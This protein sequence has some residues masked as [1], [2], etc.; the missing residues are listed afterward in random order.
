MATKK[1]SGIL[2]TSIELDGTK[3]TQSLKQLKS[4][5]N[6]TAKEYQVLEAQAKSSG[7]ELKASGLRVEGLTK[8]LSKNDEQIK[9][10]KMQMANLNTD[11]QKG[12]QAYAKLSQELLRAES[13]HTSLNNQL[14]KAQE[15][16][17][18]L[19]DGTTEL[20]RK[21]ENRNKL[22]DVTVQRLQAEGKA[23]EANAT[24]AKALIENKKDLNE[25]LE[26]EVNRLNKVTDTSGKSSREYT[27][28]AIKVEQLRGQ[29]AKTTN[30]MNSMGVK[31]SSV[32]GSLEELGKKSSIFS[33]FRGTITGASGGLTKFTGGV[34]KSKEGLLAMGASATATMAVVGKALSSIYDSQ[35][36]VSGLQAKTTLSYTKSKASISAI[37]KLYAQGYGDSIEDLQ[38]TYSKISQLNPNKSVKEL[39]ENT[40]LVSTYAKLSGADAEEVM[41]GADRATKSWGITYS[42]YFDNMIQ[43]Q[44]R[45]DDTAGDLS[46]NMSEYSQ[47]MAQM[48]LSMKDTMGLIDN[49][50]KSGAYNAD[51]LLDFTKEFGIS[52]NDGRMEKNV[53]SFN[54]QTQRMF[55]G[56]KEGKVTS[57]ELLK[58][59]TKDMAGMTDSTKEASLASTMWSALGEDNALKVVNSLG[60]TNKAFDKTKGTAKQTADQLKESNP[61]ELLKRSAT[62]S[63]SSVQM[64]ATQTKNFKKTLE[65]LQ[66]QVNKLI[67]ALIKNLP[68]IT[69]NIT[70]LV[71][72]VNAHGKTILSILGSILALH[73]ASKTINGLSG[74]KRAASSLAPIITSVGRKGKTAFMWGAKLSTKAFLKSIGAIKVATVT[75]G[76]GIGRAVKWTASIATK[77]AKLAMTGLLATARFTGNGIRLAFN[78][79]KENPLILLVSTITAVSV[80]LVELYKHNK[81]F[82]GFINGLAKAIGRNFS[83][84]IKRTIKAFNDFTD[85]VKDLWHATK[86]AFSSGW[87]AV[88]K[89]VNAFVGGVKKRFANMRKNTIK[90]VSDL[91]DSLK[92]MFGSGNKALTKITGTISDML[93]GKWS[94]IKKDVSGITSSLFNLI[95]SIAKAGYNTLNTLTG[96]GLAKVTGGWRGFSKGIKSIF[97]NL[98]SDVKKLA[99]NGINSLISVVNFGI[100]GVD[101]LIHTFGGKKQTIKPLEK[102]KF[103]TGTGATGGARRAINSLT[104]AVLNDGYDSPETGNKEMLIH[105]NG[106]MSLV[107]GRNT[108][109]LLPAG[110]EVLNATETKMFMGMQGIQRFASGTGFFSKLWKG[111]TSTVSSVTDKVKTL[112]SVITNPTKV[113][114]GM[115]K[116]ATSG[117][118]V[119]A[120]ITGG[121]SKAVT[122]QAKTWFNTL[123]DMFSNSAGS[124]SGSL[125]DVINYAKKEFGDAKYVF[126]SLK[127]TALDCSGMVKLALAH[128]GIDVPHQ[129]QEILK[130]S[131]LEKISKSEAKAGDIVGWGVGQSPTGHIGFYEGGDKFYSAMSPDSHPNVKT[132]SIA[133]M[134]RLD[135][136]KGYFRVKGLKDSSSDSDSDTGGNSLQKSIKK[137]VGSK[138]FKWIEK[139]ASPILGSDSGG[140]DQGAQSVK[141]WTSDVK[142]ALK[143]NGLS[144]S[145]NMVNKVLRQIKTESGGDA[146]AVQ[147]GYTDINTLTGNLAQGLMQ[148]IPPTFNAYK[149]KGHGN[150]LN[151][152]DNLL[153]GINYAKHRYGKSLSALGNGHGYANGGLIDRQQI[154]TLGENNQPEMVIPLSK[155]KTSRA[156]ELLSQAVAV[157]GAN[158]GVDSTANANDQANG[159]RDSKLD[160]MI[161]LLTQLVQGQANPI[162]AVVS[163]NDVYESNKK[164]ANQKNTANLM[165]RVV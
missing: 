23:E 84:Q 70:S 58:Q 50:V 154:A 123:I 6:Q 102:V 135:P 30:E 31:G 68:T 99:Q 27:N 20:N 52:L 5:V 61:F 41:Q 149:F 145:E 37:N 39:A 100:K 12:Q 96:G 105:P 119:M 148:V 134:S 94:N 108:E 161:N 8:A 42:Q 132:A 127:K 107:Q 142:K 162:R 24:K 22:T 47:V 147:H 144:T 56:Y 159:F 126:G 53:K 73:F 101:K 48:G 77:G 74:I 13:K 163:A 66:A 19:V 98:W 141:S 116:D 81:K 120:D 91:W 128:F 124:G 165:A 155:M 103:A 75:T 122:N 88:R 157:V 46:D 69:K 111:I 151:G 156:V 150:I 139:F 152:L 71:K 25:L 62:A 140:G 76:K 137:L 32:N 79:L 104:H 54:K 129:S 44:K 90:L 2:S 114:N 49:G 112:S 29:I 28:Q 59:V 4:A 18:K 133:G 109:M 146:S 67:K 64:N 153:A 9:A 97:S 3:A 36:Q 21:I 11:T 38:E 34:L 160:T 118:G 131:Q 86:N 15:W 7:D 1:I 10:T 33:K 80:A 26:K 57:G 51:K 143:M 63:L 164:I 93:H 110:T 136:F 43:L 55:A 40:K 35:S 45:G 14:K 60:K 17:S 78:F 158:A 95:K 115:F 106:N 82:R 121:I 85:G 138:V 89:I 87:H 92:D 117:S 125:S 83:R 72:F 130:S 16:N 65:P 113:F